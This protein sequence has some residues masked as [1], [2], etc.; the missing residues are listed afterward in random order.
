M[1]QHQLPLTADCRISSSCFKEILSTLSCL[2]SSCSSSNSLLLILTSLLLLRLLLLPVPPTCDCKLGPLGSG[3][4]IRMWV[5][6]THVHVNDNAYVFVFLTH[7][8]IQGWKAC[9]L[10]STCKRDSL[11]RKASTRWN[12][13]P[14]VVRTNESEIEPQQHATQHTVLQLFNDC[15]ASK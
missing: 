7:L 15:D 14:V 12:S 10:H 1:H 8:P 4:P 2:S 13:Y 3:Q 9:T 11:P 6:S 5:D